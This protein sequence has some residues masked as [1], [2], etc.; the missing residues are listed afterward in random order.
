[1]TNAPAPEPRTE[2][3]TLARLAPLSGVAFFVLTVVALAIEGRPPAYDE[4]TDEVVR[5]WIDN[6]TRGIVATEVGGLSSALLVWFGGSVQAA[7]RR[8]E[9]EPGRV[10]A[11][12][13]GGFVI[14]AIGNTALFGFAFAAAETAGDVPAE[15]TH[16]MSAL[17]ELFVILFSLGMLV[18]LLATTVVTL[19]HASLL[20]RWSAVASIVAAISLMAPIGFV[21][22]IPAMFWVLFASV[23]LFVRERRAHVCL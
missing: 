15:V 23:L 19:R 5:W 10:A 6:D 14:A 18:A 17:S 3:S 7:L 16:T 1:M 13:F 4:P 20:P 2:P 8:A 12:A 22:A 9:R 21:A 11:I